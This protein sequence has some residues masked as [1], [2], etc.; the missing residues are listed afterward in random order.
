MAGVDPAIHVFLPDA[1]LTR[2]CPRKR[3]IQ[4]SE[5]LVIESKTRG[6]LNTPLAGYDE[7]LWCS[8]LRRLPS[9]GGEGRL[10]SREADARRGGV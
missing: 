9:P 3:V 8:R 6:V 7:S 10:A 4:Y 1:P 2:G 5:T